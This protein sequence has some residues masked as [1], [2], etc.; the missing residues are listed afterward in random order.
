MRYF[1]KNKAIVG[2]ILLIITALIWGCA[3]VAQ[4]VGM[5]Y[6]G[7]FTFNGTRCIIGGIVLII[8]NIIFDAVKKKNGSYRKP[9]AE[10][11]NNET[12][13]DCLER[14]NGLIGLKEV[15]KSVAK[16]INAFRMQ[17]RHANRKELKK[18]KLWKKNG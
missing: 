2:N 18:K 1:M 11:R 9:S 12:S 4:S 17:K 8:A 7:P 13:L 16:I 5:D 6:V 15:K 14:L 10:E 3:F